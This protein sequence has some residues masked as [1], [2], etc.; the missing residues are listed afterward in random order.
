MNYTKHKIRLDRGRMWYAMF[1]SLITAGLVY[2][3]SS[4]M[5]IWYKVLSAVGSFIMVYLLGFIDDK[6][7]LVDREQKGYSERNPVLMEIKEK[8]DQLTAL[9]QK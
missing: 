2:V 3:F 6:L 4:E 5:N 7:R 8:L 1:Q 9:H